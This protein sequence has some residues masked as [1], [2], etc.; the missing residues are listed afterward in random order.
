M[1]AS[2]SKNTTGE[3]IH[4]PTALAQNPPDQPTSQIHSYRRPQ[5]KP[6]QKP[7]PKP[8]ESFG[9]LKKQHPWYDFGPVLSHN[10]AWNIIPGARGIGKTFGAKKLAINAFIKRGDQFIYL[11]R[12]KE[13]LIARDTF[14]SDIAYLYP[15]WE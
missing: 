1:V 14:F 7:E 9:P 2:C 12:Y 11:R 6:R 10:G 5:G 13:E 15:D 4:M 3:H 8:A